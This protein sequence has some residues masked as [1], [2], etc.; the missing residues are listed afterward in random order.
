MNTE[1]TT[2]VDLNAL[3]GQ[4]LL[5]AQAEDPVEVLEESLSVIKALIEV[6]RCAVPVFNKGFVDAVQQ[7]T[8]RMKNARH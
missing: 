4:Q 1:S 6:V 3:F 7:L 5:L 8:E 2:G